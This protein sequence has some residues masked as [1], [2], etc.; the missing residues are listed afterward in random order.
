MQDGERG[1]GA[2]QRRKIGAE[3][4]KPA[5]RPPRPEMT[6][7]QKLEYGLMYGS[8]VDSLLRGQPPDEVYTGKSNL[9]RDRPQP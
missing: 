1:Q 4:P 5:P 6:P 8:Q 2:P 7:T 9:N 3:T